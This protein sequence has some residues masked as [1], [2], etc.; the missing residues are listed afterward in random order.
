M[1]GCNMTQG[2]LSSRATWPR[3]KGVR[4][5]RAKRSDMNTL[6]ILSLH[7]RD[8]APLDYISSITL[9]L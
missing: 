1:M 5:P 2:L 6:L 9:S 4:G 8:L 3:A 7:C